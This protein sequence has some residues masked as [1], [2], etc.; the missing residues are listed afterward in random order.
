M[1]DLLKIEKEKLQKK[2][3]LIK[4]NDQKIEQ[5]FDKIKTCFTEVSNINIIY[6]SFIL[7]AIIFI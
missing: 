1:Q 2:Q 3:K 6:K 5:I 4:E 7:S